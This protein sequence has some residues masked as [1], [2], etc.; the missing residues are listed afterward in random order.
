MAGHILIAQGIL[1]YGGI[2]KEWLRL[3]IGTDGC[4]I[5]AQFGV[6]AAQIVMGQR[7]TA[8]R[9]MSIVVVDGK[10]YERIAGKRYITLVIG[11][12][13]KQGIEGT[14][15]TM[16]TGVVDAIEHVVGCL[17]IGIDDLLNGFQTM[18]WCTVSA[19]CQ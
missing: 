16:Q 7:C 1:T 4:G 13:G 9:G 17:G 2:G 14:C 6:G 15:L 18:K 12:R 19:G 5:I 11:L 8:V 10:A 3:H